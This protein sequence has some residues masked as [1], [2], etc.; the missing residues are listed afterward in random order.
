MQ[1]EKI[2]K[3][4][5]SKDP[6]EC[7]KIVELD[8]TI[9]RLIVKNLFSLKCIGTDKPVLFR[10]KLYWKPTYYVYIQD[11]VSIVRNEDESFTLQVDTNAMLTLGEEICYGVK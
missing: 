8:E 1:T 11:G 4:V 10:G 9:V 3:G 5:V 7:L 6:Q 2:K